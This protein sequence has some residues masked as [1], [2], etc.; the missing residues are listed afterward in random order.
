MNT[1]PAD[2]ER[3]SEVERGPKLPRD[4]PL[5]PGKS[6]SAGDAILFALSHARA[7]QE[8]CYV[9]GGDSVLVSLTEVTDL[10]ETD[11]CTGRALFQVTWKPLG[12][13]G[14]P[15]PAAKRAAKPQRSPQ[16]S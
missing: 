10:D 6:L 13:S 7:G 15:V 14:T 8:P 2:E 9:K 5:P 3:I 1:Y 16:K 4:P 11:P 12:Q